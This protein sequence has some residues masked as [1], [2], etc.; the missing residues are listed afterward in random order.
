MEHVEQTSPIENKELLDLRILF[1]E[2]DESMRALV[3]RLLRLRYKHVDVV[4]NGAF[5]MQKLLTSGVS[6]DCVVTDNNMPI[7]KGIE[8]LREI[9]KVEG[10]KTLPVIVLTSDIENDLEREIKTL[11][12]V[13]LF[14]TISRKVLYPTIEGAVEAR[15]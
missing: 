8:A 3:E 14:K 12:G 2:D 1:A 6:Y 10:L 15:K 11:G 13:Y 5:L 4:G 9:R 7:T